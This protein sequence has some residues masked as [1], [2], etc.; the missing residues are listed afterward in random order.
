MDLSG[1][2]GGLAQRGIDLFPIDVSGISKCRK[3]QRG[4]QHQNRQV[5]FH[6]SLLWFAPKP[7]IDAPQITPISRNTTPAAQ[8]PASTVSMPMLKRKTAVAA[9][10]AKTSAGISTLDKTGMSNDSPN[11]RTGKVSRNTVCSANQID[12]L[13]ITPTTAAVIAVSAPA[14]PLLPRRIS[15]K[16]APRKIHRKHGVKVTHV[17]SNPPSVPASIGDSAPGSR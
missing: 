3:S 8:D 9:A 12:R 13:R 4:D 7:L 6:R 11:D 16:G 14:N 17:A 1:D 5:S 2:R 15:M 10:I